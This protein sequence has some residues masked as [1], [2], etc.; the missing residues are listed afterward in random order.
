[1]DYPTL[2]HSWLLIISFRTTCISNETAD[3]CIHLDLYTRYVNGLRASTFAVFDWSK[4][5]GQLAWLSVRCCIHVHLILESICYQRIYAVSD[6]T[7]LCLFSY[8]FLYLYLF[9]LLQ[10]LF[11][12]FLGTLYFLFT[13]QHK[14]HVH[15]G[16]KV[17]CISCEF[18]NAMYAVH[19]S[20]IKSLKHGV[21]IQPG[22][23]LTQSGITTVIYNTIG[24]IG[25]DMQVLYQELQATPDL[26]TVN[27]LMFRIL[28]MSIAVLDSIASTQQ[29]FDAVTGYRSVVY[30]SSYPFKNNIF[31]ENQNTIN[32]LKFDNM[33]F[34][35]LCNA[36]KHDAP[37]IGI[38]STRNQ[39]T[40]GKEKRLWDIYDP[41]GVGMFNNIIK[42]CYESM[43]T[44]VVQMSENIHEVIKIELPVIF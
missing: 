34:R 8:L 5:C 6:R 22:L 40:D 18:C 24:H 43:C 28:T 37:W 26:F 9:F 16:Q 42:K 33:S 29:R 17:M 25:A 32:S 31:S 41:V 7:G 19:V 13:V 10:Y 2:N 3:K 15:E 30:F 38:L 23:G 12:Y 14:L 20:N 1:M 27:S 4:W 35:E 36:L 39:S 11:L 21:V 44:L